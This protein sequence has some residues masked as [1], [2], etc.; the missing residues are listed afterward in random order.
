LT[1]GGGG[2]VE[3]AVSRNRQQRRVVQITL[4]FCLN[5]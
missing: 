3:Q 5:M 1:V 2:E 4:V